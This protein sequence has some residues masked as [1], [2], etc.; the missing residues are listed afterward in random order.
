MSDSLEALRDAVRAG[1]RFEY[2]MFWR[3]RAAADGSVTASCLSQWWMGDFVVDGA[4]Y[5]SAEQW[6]MAGK[7]RLFG[8]DAALAAVMAENDPAKVKKLGRT[9]RGFDTARWRAACE[10][11]VTRGNEAKFSQDARLRAYLLGTGDA[12]LVEASPHDAVWGIGLGA[13]DERATDPLRWPGENLLGFALMR[14]R[15]RLR[16][17]NA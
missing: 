14:A 10:E 15:E 17:A 3:P 1:Q 2:V 4:T 11:H 12:V 16:S 9:V 7:A 6:M 8:D 5:S 13:E